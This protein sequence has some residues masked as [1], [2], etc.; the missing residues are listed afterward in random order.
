VGIR[1]SVNGWNSAL[2]KRPSLLAMLMVVCALLVATSPALAG[3]P[4]CLRIGT[5]AN[6][7]WSLYT[8]LGYY[9]FTFV[10]PLRGTARRYAVDGQPTTTN[11]NANDLNITASPDGKYITRVIDIGT[12]QIPKSRF[13]LTSSG[14]DRRPITQIDYDLPTDAIKLTWLSD[15]LHL[16][17]STESDDGSPI[18]LKLLDLLGNIVEPPVG[19]SYS[20]KQRFS[21]VAMSQGNT[22]I[23]VLMS[24]RDGEDMHLEVWSMNDLSIIKTV[25]LPGLFY[26]LEKTA[27]E[28]R[29]GNDEYAYLRLFGNDLSL[30]FKSL[31]SQHETVLPL[32]S[33]ANNLQMQT[34]YSTMLAWSP[35]GKYLSVLI[36]DVR[37]WS[38]S[39]LHIADASGATPIL[40]PN[41][42]Q[43]SA[44]DCAGGCFEP[45]VRWTKDG[46]AI[47]FL[48]HPLHNLTNMS[49]EQNSL[50]AY[51]SKT[52]QY[53]SLAFKVWFGITH[54]E[55]EEWLRVIHVLE[56]GNTFEY[57]EEYVRTDGTD[58]WT[59]L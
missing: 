18:A 1:G 54:D 19:I 2:M 26:N 57:K 53:S 11:P 15:R 55:A 31:Q 6:F 38:L 16:L 12:Q 44:Q 10:E 28:W 59:A 56:E 43:V 9:D 48:Q 47:H 3:S 23:V 46:N 42:A 58:K 41:V 51:F 4:V 40:Q 33:K 52:K 37:D 22:Q 5:A 27:L 45:R 7:G 36:N 24:G 8:H 49:S 20:P 25:P 14:L 34:S 21:Y 39:T 13:V 17:V 35:S 30:V 29:P 50:V 32:P